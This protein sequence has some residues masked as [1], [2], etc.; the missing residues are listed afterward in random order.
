MNKIYIL[1]DYKNIFG[2]KHYATRYRSGM[3][4]KLLEKYF[5]ENGYE[6][7][8]IKFA[9]INFRKMNFKDQYIIYTSSEDLKG[10]YK[11]YI[12]DII[13]G[14]HLQ[15]TKLIP[16]YKYLKAHNN[17]VF[18]EILRD[19]TF[20]DDSG[21]I[22]SNYFG[23]VEE[24]K[25]NLNKISFPAVIKS[26]TGAMSRGVYLSKNK[27]ELVKTVKKISRSRDLL[28]ELWDYGRSLKH[29]GYIKESKYRNK[30]I[31]Q[32]FIPNLKNDWKILIYG[33]RY[34][35]LYRGVR[36][37]DFRASGSGKFIFTDD[38]PNGILDYAKQ[39]FDI[40]NVPNLSIDIA[41]DGNKFY[42]LEFQAIYYGTT[43]IEKSSFYFKNINN[44]W[45]IIK[46][47]PILEKIYVE[48]ILNFIN[49]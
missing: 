42:L 16:E 24:L 25:N 21:S 39:I 45:E 17:K 37:N 34:Y 22:H 43:T 33:D 31:V 11:S 40:L 10:H 49:K 9:D 35:I 6:T 3:D 36:D 20:N 48:S 23:T 44:S 19:L 27:K 7:I 26:A 38:I 41:F 30:F 28:A 46:E 5:K 47:K 32:N 12:E 18:M 13:Y 29:K 4:K 1:T 14:L 2:S 15:R 8:F